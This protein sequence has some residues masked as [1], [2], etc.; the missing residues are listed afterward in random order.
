MVGADGPRVSFFDD[1]EY[2]VAQ[3]H[4]PG[5]RLEPGETWLLSVDDQ[6]SRGS[7]IMWRLQPEA[8]R[9]PGHAVF[10]GRA[11][12]SL[13]VASALARLEVPLLAAPSSLGD[14]VEWA[15]R[16]VLDRSER[17]VEQLDGPSFG[18]AM[19]LAA[20]SRL[21]GLGLS[22]TLVASA[23]VSESG[24]VEEVGGLEV[25]L[26]LLDHAAFANREIT[27][28]V[29]ASQEEEAAELAP[30]HVRV[31]GIDRLA[32]A[33]EQAFQAPELTAH[34]RRRWGSVDERRAAAATF[35][36]LA[37]DGSNQLLG[38]RSLAEGASLL[39]SLTAED[40]WHW[41]VDVAARI[42]WR[43]A[44]VPEPLELGRER[45]ASLPRP[46]RTQLLAHTVQ[47]AADAVS[48]GW[49]SAVTQ[50]WSYLPDPG[51]EHAEDLVLLGALGRTEAAWGRYKR[52]DQALTRAVA[53]WLALDAEP[54]S[55][56]A[57][58]ELLRVRGV[59]GRAL[60]GSVVDA[61]R[62]FEQDP[63]P[64]S[65]SQAFV[66]AAHGRA[67]AQHGLVE[68]ATTLLGSGVCWEH[69]PVHLQAS[70]LRW[71][72]WALAER[73]NRE[74]ARARWEELQEL[75]AR[76]PTVASF[77]ERLAALDR[78]ALGAGDELGAVQTGAGQARVSALDG[79]LAD[80]QMGPEAHRI[81]G[82]TGAESAAQQAW[83][84]RWHWRY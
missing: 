34:L 60:E 28:L 8:P 58:S 21:I 77:A 75:A 76:K 67:L 15:A 30:K 82:Y 11:A 54:R 22:S 17:L 5:S 24:R 13:Q 62:R 52:A 27:C 38:W 49:E 78:E 9:G 32:E 45:L 42:A 3:A 43:H 19:V 1:M 74:S 6:G 73:G 23:S 37:V 20:S 65:T 64:D 63:R 81:L 57:L 14:R 55:S 16:N 84:V 2:A 70:R 59:T 56:Y 66:R 47:A 79:V 39:G 29:A 25:K 4:G 68:D 26:G 51:E 44:N 71:L 31:V 12:R 7:A 53:G 35:F 83:A 33:I 41:K 36:R 50:G 72:A 46:R 61:L 40:P 10:R 69:V 18:L 80:P 48:E